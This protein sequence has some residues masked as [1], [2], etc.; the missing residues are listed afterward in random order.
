[1]AL[2]FLFLVHAPAVFLALQSTPFLFGSSGFLR[3]NKCIGE[4]LEMMEYWI[5]IVGPLDSSGSEVL[6]YV[7]DT[8]KKEPK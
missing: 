2:F 1:M 5:Q 7:E 6:S 3:I 4:H 8:D